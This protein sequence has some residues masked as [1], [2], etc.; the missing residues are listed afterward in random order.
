M[1]QS[2]TAVIYAR[3]AMRPFTRRLCSAAPNSVCC[4]EANFLLRTDTPLGPKVL[5][6]EE[7]EEE[8]F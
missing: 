4:V 3:A 8:F 2:M 7:E 1:P 5:F 6:F